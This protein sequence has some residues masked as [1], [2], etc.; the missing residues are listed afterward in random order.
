M[1]DVTPNSA[2]PMRVAKSSCD[3]YT[4][5]AGGGTRGN[6][7][8]SGC[9]GME[10]STRRRVTGASL[11]FSMS[12]TP[13]AP[14]T[15]MRSPVLMRRVASDV[16]DD[17]RQAELARDDGGVRGHAAGVGDEPR[18]AR[19]EHDPRRV[20]HAADEDL[21]VLDLVELVERLDDARAPLG[22]ARRGRQA[23]DLVGRAGCARG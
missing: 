23:D 10:R 7:S 6:V 4:Q 3:S 17:G 9:T 13:V 16:P 18:D 14:F 2:A 8:M 5:S 15:R 12:T 21:A 20:R 22:D 19:E 11:S 1:S